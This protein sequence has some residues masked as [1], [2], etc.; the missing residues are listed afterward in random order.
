MKTSL[1][2]TLTLFTF[3]ALSVVPNIFA[4][5]ASP[6]YV[7]RTIYI[8]PNDREPDPNMD[9]KLN[10]LMK[11]TQQFYADLMEFHGFGRKTFRLETDATGDVIVHHVNGKHSDAHYQ[12]DSEGSMIVWDEIKEQFDTSK[13]IHVL[14]LDI[15]GPIIVYGGGEV[16]GL[17]DMHSH[18]GMALVPASNPD[19]ALWHELGHTFGLTHDSRVEANRWINPGSVD[20]M[21]TSFC[22]AEWM[23]VN[24]YFNPVQ[25][26][27]VLDD[28]EAR[29]EMLKPS[30]ASSPYAIRLQ[31]KVADPDG[32][33][34]AQLSR[35]SAYDAGV[36]ACKKL[37][38]NEATVEFVTS[39]LIGGGI[40]EGVGLWLMDMHGNFT[41]HDFPIDITDLL[42]K[43][44]EISI[45]D[46]NL[47]SAVR[48]T[49]DLTPGDAITQLVMRR[50]IN[51]RATDRQIT[52]LTGLEHAVN[53]QGLFLDNNQIRDLTPLAE[54]NGLDVLEI[55]EN[56]ISDITPLKKL[57][58]L[59]ELSCRNAQISDIAPL[60]RLTTLTKLSLV[61]NPIIDIT[62][63]AGLTN[64]FDLDLGSSQQP[65]N[66]IAPLAGLVNLKGLTLFNASIK[67]TNIISSFTEL[68]H[69]TFIEVPIEDVRFLTELAKL[70]SLELTSCK[71]DNARPFAV[72]KNLAVLNLEDNQ[73]SDVSPLAE[74]AN[75]EELGLAGNPIEDTKPL[76]ALLRK[77]PDVKIYLE[78][79]GDPFLFVEL[80]HF[81]AQRT[82][83]GVVLKW[84]TE[85]EFDTAGFNILRSETKNGTFKILNPELIKGAGTTDKQNEYTWTDT[86]AKPNTV[87]YFQL[88]DVSHAGVRKQLATVTYSSGVSSV[89]PLESNLTT[90]GNIKRT[91]LLQNYPNP[92]NPETWIPYQLAEDAMV[93]LTIYNSSG[94]VVRTLE[95]GNQSS[96][97]YESRDKAAYWDG[98]NEDGELVASGVYFYQL[99][100]GGFTSLR[101]MVILK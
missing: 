56:P 46:P 89:E 53:M 31:F 26:A 52:D 6:K 43:A 58:I 28:T 18:Y 27:V 66:D 84:T 93:T 41:S 96:A 37:N 68:T 21:I 7:V 38:G 81:S 10:T 45:P 39:H 91:A 13:N 44:K 40:S 82:D 77:N 15:S 88:E 25:E 75:L 54:A 83:A 23:D 90:L 79:G 67:D 49:L 64:L 71:I 51:F 76:R 87:Y 17:A 14:A 16:S 97:S 60:A 57:K 94:L 80:S 29:V 70:S 5:D 36:I 95:L 78:Y 73:I 63:L 47:A 100:A 74:L 69:L 11:D 12:N 92:F 2:L 20:P 1:C 33:H 72:L 30:S 55:S 50:L 98:R 101:R 4:Q 61:G 19:V 62:P 99:R 9:A 59:S 42:P 35:S 48:E 65:I 86:T 34:Q 24:R 22:A 85:S 8:V 3:I 32:L